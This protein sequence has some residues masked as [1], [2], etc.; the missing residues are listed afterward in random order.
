MIRL[1]TLLRFVRAYTGQPLREALR[2]A[3][4]L[5]LGPKVTAAILTLAATLDEATRIATTPD[6]GRPG[7][8]PADVLTFLLDKTGYVEALRATRDPQDEARIE[9]GV[10]QDEKRIDQDIAERSSHQAPKRVRSSASPDASGCAK[11]APHSRP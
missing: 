8:A 6:G 3:D 11:P 10:G 1:F 2:D 5:G 9:T 4:Q 7:G